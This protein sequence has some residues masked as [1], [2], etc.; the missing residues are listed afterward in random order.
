MRAPDRSVGTGVPGSSTDSNRSTVRSVRPPPRY[1]PRP[2]RWPGKSASSCDFCGPRTVSSQRIT[3]FS[4]GTPRSP[5][6][7]REQPFVEPEQRV[8]VILL[9]LDVERLVVV[10][11]V[12]DRRQVELLRVGL[13][14]AGVAVGGPLHRGADAVAVAEVKVVA[15][16]DLVAVV[17][18]RR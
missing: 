9:A 7:A 8:R 13:G 1:Q 11:R 4:A 18:D 5:A 2:R 15:H 6:P 14:E 10:L 3:T 16:A 12:D 17:Q